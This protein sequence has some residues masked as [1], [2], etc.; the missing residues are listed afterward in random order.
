M[1]KVAIVARRR[2]G[3]TK[4]GETLS[5]SSEEARVLVALKFA[6]YPKREAP[7]VEAKPKAVEPEIAKERRPYKRR[8][9]TAESYET[10]PMV[11]KSGPELSFVP[12]AT[13]STPSDGE[14]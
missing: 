9:L 11:A 3:K 1:P 6:E 13:H 2:I 5:V 12:T 4:P 14:A 8:D 10:R 7:K